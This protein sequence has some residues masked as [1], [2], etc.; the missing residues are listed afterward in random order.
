MLWASI[1][2]T[3]EFVN[4]RDFAGVLMI[5][6]TLTLLTAWSQKEIQQEFSEKPSFPA[7]MA[8]YLKPISEPAPINDFLK[9]AGEELFRPRK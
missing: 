8:P 4:K 7:I 1:K 9:E 5:T 6:L 3:K 2:L